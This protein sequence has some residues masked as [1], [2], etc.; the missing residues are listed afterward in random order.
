MSKREEGPTHVH[1]SKAKKRKGVGSRTITIL[2]SDEEVPMVSKERARMTR[3]RVTVSGKTEG[4]SKSSIPI[5]EVERPSISAV[6]AEDVVT[7][8]V[9]TP[10]DIVVP[11]L[12][13]KRSKRVND[14]V[15]VQPYLPFP[16]AK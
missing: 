3:T 16:I 8:D 1:T 12:P 2:D 4:V 14:S 9:D 11:V 15:S 5:F 10:M 6:L 13:P 7:E